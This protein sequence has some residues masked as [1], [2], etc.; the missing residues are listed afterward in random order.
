MTSYQRRLKEIEALNILADA[1]KADLVEVILNPDSIK[2]IEIKAKV[3][4]QQELIE[5]ILWGYRGGPSNGIIES[6]IIK[7][8]KS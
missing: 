5:S 2:S 3:K 8:K 1:Y 4:M 6:V 7:T